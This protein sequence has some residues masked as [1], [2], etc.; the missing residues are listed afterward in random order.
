MFHSCKQPARLKGIA[1]PLIAQTGGSA[2]GHGADRGSG[3]D[4]T[5]FFACAFV[6]QWREGRLAGSRLLRADGLLGGERLD[7]DSA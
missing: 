6:P 5:V 3:V 2:H 1:L 4:L 7:L